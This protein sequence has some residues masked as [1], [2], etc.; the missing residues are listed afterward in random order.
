VWRSLHCAGLIERAFGLGIALHTPDVITQDLYHEPNPN[1]LLRLG[2]DLVSLPGEPIVEMRLPH[3]ELSVMDVCCLLL[4][5]ENGWLLVTQDG[6][7]FS[8][9]RSRAVAVEDTLWLVE[10]MVQAGTLT[11]DEAAACVDAMVARG[12]RLP[13]TRTELF[14]KRWR[15]RL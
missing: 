3:P 12:R 1:D 8:L 2:L 14:L 4:A 7:L 11:G 15:R 6:P 10:C 13:H 9:A 5:E